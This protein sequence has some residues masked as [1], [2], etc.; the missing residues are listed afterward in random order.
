[1]EIVVPIDLFAKENGLIADEAVS[2]PEYFRRPSR[3]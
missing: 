3:V 1:V 2:L